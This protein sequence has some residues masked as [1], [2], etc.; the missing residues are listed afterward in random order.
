MLREMA[1][2]AR[3]GGIVA[4]REVDYS[5]TTWFP[6]VPELELWL[7]LVHRVNGG[8]PDAG[9]YLTSWTLEAELPQPR[10]SD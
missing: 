8:E 3:P 9:R 5:A 7:D 1:R 10:F 6:L 4:A 2:V